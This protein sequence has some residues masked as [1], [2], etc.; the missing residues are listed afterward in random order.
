MAPIPLARWSELRHAYG[1]ADDIPA[2]LESARV[3]LRPGSDSESAWFQL[4]SALCHQG[5]AYSASYAA[6]PTLAS[7]AKQRHGRVQYDPL[8]LIGCIELARLERRAPPI[9]E[10][11]LQGYEDA[12]QEAR[13]MI[14][15][16]LAKKLDEEWRSALTADLAS[17]RGDVTKARTLLDAD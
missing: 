7:I 4:W 5:D 3:D 2:L 17:L 9:P 14:E 11:L 16:L 1:P 8:C 15:G 12:K 13:K 10:D 6:A